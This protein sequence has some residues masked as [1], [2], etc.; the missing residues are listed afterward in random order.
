MSGM[1]YQFTPDGTMS[2]FASGT[3]GAAGVVFDG[4][5]DLFVA[6]NVDGTISKFT[7]DGTK[8][9]FASGLTQATF[10]AFEPL[11]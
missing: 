9:T 5:G 8:S 6:S 2:I 11:P 1:V 7:P 4:D 3:P 10:L